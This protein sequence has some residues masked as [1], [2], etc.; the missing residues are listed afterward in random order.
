M[1]VN[2]SLILAKRL[3]D[4]Q[5]SEI[6][7]SFIE[8]KSIYDLSK[9]FE[10]TNLTISRNLKKILGNEKYKEIIENKNNLEKS[11][12]IKKNFSKENS[13]KNT[14]EESCKKK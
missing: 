8:G 6:T 9:V 13:N 14:I 7:Q 10:C 2:S 12:S 4:K 5:K 11:F 1:K 3:T